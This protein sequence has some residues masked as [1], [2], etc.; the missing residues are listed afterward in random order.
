MKL[1]RYSILTSVFI[2]LLG[3]VLP[4]TL[5]RASRVKAAELDTSKYT[6]GQT[7]I[8][9]NGE[10]ISEGT[11]L[12]FEDTLR[13]STPI[14]VNDDV[15]I[16]EGDTITFD[17]PAE[18]QPITKLTFAITDSYGEAV[19]N[20][21]TDPTTKKVTVTFTDRFNTLKENRTVNVDFDVNLAREVRKED[22]Q[23]IITINGKPVTVDV[24]E[25]IGYDDKEM[26]NKWGKVNPEDP[27]EIIWEARVNSNKHSI[28]GLV[29]EDKFNA[30]EMTLVGVS[31]LKDITSW[32][33]GTGSVEK[34]YDQNEIDAITTKTENGF[35]INMGDTEHIVYLKYTT[36]L[37]DGQTV[38]SV[39]NIITMRYDSDQSAE[40]ESIVQTVKGG[41]SAT[42]EAS[43]SQVIKAS[44]TIS[45]RAIVEG[46][47]EFELKDE[48]GTVLQTAKNAADGSV[49][50]DQV[51]FAT[52]GVFNYTISEKKG[53][54][55][56][57][58][59]DTKE[60]S[61][62]VTVTD[63]KGVKTAKLEYVDG[64][65]KFANAYQA[66][67]IEVSLAAKKVLI[68]QDLQAGAFTFTA[69]SSDTDAPSFKE[70]KN[71]EDGT[72][73]FG[74]ASFTKAGTYT[75]TLKEVKGSQAGVTY[76]ETEHTAIVTV[77]A[78]ETSGQL[79]AAVTYDGQ[80]V[81]PTF[82][83]SYEAKPVSV[84]L[85]ASKTLSGRSLKA[86][87]FTFTAVSEDENAP[88]F[89]EAKNAKDG[90]VVFE[91]ATFTQAGTYTFTISEKDEAL[92]GITYDADQFKATVTVTDNGQGHLEAQVAYSKNNKAFDKAIFKNTYSAK[93]VKKTITAKK[94]LVGRE[95]KAEE[96]TFQLLEDG[97][98]I[99]TAKNDKD[100][101]IQFEEQTYSEAGDHEYEIKEVIEN[102]PG[103]DYD[104]STHKAFVQVT[105]NGQ[106]QLE[107]SLSYDN[108]QDAPLFQNGYESKPVLVSLKAQK[109]LKGRNL[110]AGEFEFNAQ[111][112]N[113][114]APDFAFAKNDKDGQVVFEAIAFTQAGSFVYEIS[115]ADHQL[116]GVT[117]DKSI[118]LAQ[119]DV[120]DN[121]KGQLEAKVTYKQNGKEVEEPVFTNNYQA[122]AVSVKVAAKKVLTG[123][124]LKDGEFTFELLENDQVLA[125]AK[126]DKDGNIIF[127]QV[128]YKEVG[129]HTYQIREVAGQDDSLVYDSSLHQVQVTIT[130]DGEGL[131]SAQVIYDDMQDAT[132]RPTFKNQVKSQEP[133]KDEKKKD[134]ESSKAEEKKNK[135]MLPSTGSQVSY[136][137]LA[138]GFIMILMTLTLVY[139]K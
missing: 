88:S 133:K 66:D 121:G 118:Y 117:Y 35:V 122:Q 59:Y 87:E 72:I 130:D 102:L 108:G 90:Q 54:D 39:K 1:K 13:V 70:G 109:I 116:P 92:A 101:I 20:I 80:E 103:I 76:D 14:T 85:E 128:T 134:L 91:A 125:T 113:L 71:A 98:V 40:K 69:T 17:L 24:T 114:A 67:P 43:D 126:N 139:K 28:K 46:E 57:V 82:T 49:T 15:Q 19:A 12:T 27:T 95:L 138:L 104:K 100:G 86:E 32:P 127:D 62:K 25:I 11:K 37:K 16:N 4:L 73:S 93:A 58:T 112:T 131:L 21:E 137:L 22:G 129:Q 42:G 48:S 83:N 38:D 44:K 74:S 34:N 111:S 123:R 110:S 119:V 3:L 120:T 89:A 23:T 41:G 36:K 61:V 106:G 68:G 47:F 51:K 8:S 107:A 18:V 2:L 94:E 78:D 132:Y 84:S 136:M 45:G 31:E 29:I 64:E 99:A 77:S 65:A 115:E 55:T 52:V 63:D 50:F 97:K 56:H 33:F 10:P 96:F 79:S 6:I 26:I 30:A 75:Y 9:L 81:E 60:Y 5:L 53:S 7:S 105:D 135:N 124:D